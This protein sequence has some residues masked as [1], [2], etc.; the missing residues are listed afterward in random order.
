MYHSE[1]FFAENSVKLITFT[2][3]VSSAFKILADSSYIHIC[4]YEEKT[5]HPEKTTA[6]IRCT[7]GSGEIYAG[8]KRFVLN[9]NEYI[10][11]R[12]S[13]I[14]KYKS[15]S[16]LWGYEWVNFEAD[17]RT[18]CDLNKIGISQ[19]SNEEALQFD[20][21]IEAGKSGAER[22]YLNAL[23]LNYFYMVT[24]E[25]KKSIEKTASAKKI[26]FADEICSFIEQKIYEK[27]TVTDA[28]LFFN[29]SPRRLHQIF[30]KELGI[31]P[32]QYI[33]KKKME[34]GYRLL[35]QTTYPINKISEV[36]CF[37]SAYHFSNEFK[38]LF[39]QTPT[40]VRNM[41]KADL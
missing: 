17:D 3:I 8:G 24:I 5:V 16:N 23:F 2:P 27:I 11:L 19:R 38:K 31:S 1:A 20:K 25:N 33:V 40:Q 36:L 6:F 13:D 9:E 4:E 15:I 29:I 32:K 10:M 18:L 39:K 14:E 7:A 37:S 34:E 28:A 21:F 12:F 30:A 26:K 41:E 35:V 22:N